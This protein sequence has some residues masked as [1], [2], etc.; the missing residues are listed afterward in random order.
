MRPRAPIHPADRA[1]A[2][3]RRHGLA[4]LLV[5][6]L[7]LH[8]LSA[9]MIGLLG[10]RHYHDA[11][12]AHALGRTLHDAAPAHLHQHGIERHHHAHDD[13]SVVPLDPLKADDAASDG[14]SSAAPSM[15]APPPGHRIATR[16]QGRAPWQAAPTGRFVS[17]SSQP[18]ER[19]P[20]V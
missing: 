13:A 3:L 6:A 2:A 17:W 8:G 4:W 15:L 7:P 5:L 19:P 16:T 14:T 11:A 20:K 1:V 18:P 12:Q 9:A 10:Q